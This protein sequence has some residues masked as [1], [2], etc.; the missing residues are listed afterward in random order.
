MI[1]QSAPQAADPSLLPLR[2]ILTSK[3]EGG[4]ACCGQNKNAAPNRER[5]FLLQVFCFSY[6]TTNCIVFTAV[7][8]VSWIMYNPAASVS[9]DSSTRLSPSLALIVCCCSLLPSRSVT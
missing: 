6:F 9:V 3:G 4:K 1:L 7:P 2:L 5:R 8:S